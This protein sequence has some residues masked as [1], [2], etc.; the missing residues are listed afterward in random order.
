MAVVLYLST[1]I[2]EWPDSIL[3]AVVASLGGLAFG[4]VLSAFIDRGIHNCPLFYLRLEVICTVLMPNKYKV[5]RF[6]LNRWIA[7]IIFVL[8]IL[9]GGLIFIFP[10]VFYQVVPGISIYGGYNE[11]LV[12]D[13]GLVYFSSGLMGMLARLGMNLAIYLCAGL[14]SILHGLYH[15]FEWFLRGSPLDLIFAFDLLFV[16][17]PP[18]LV[19]AY[20]FKSARDSSGGA[21]DG[22]H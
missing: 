10:A 15:I 8:W 14:W 16:V 7:E 2:P 5:G 13:L 3:L 20:L 21:R 17:L 18:L 9:T 1:V 19:V 22:R 11:H 4:R 12:R 6:F